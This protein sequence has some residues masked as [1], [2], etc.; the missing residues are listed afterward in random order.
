MVAFEAAGHAPAKLT[1]AQVA[2]KVRPA[3][4]TIR[5]TVFRGGVSEGQGFLFGG[6]GHVLTS[7][8]VLVHATKV[9]VVNAQG[10]TGSVAVVGIDKSLDIAELL[11]SDRETTPLAA[12]GAVPG[13]GTPIVVVGN[14]YSG[15]PYSVLN[16]AV[17]GTG[18][19][20]ALKSGTLGDLVATDVAVQPINSGG[21]LVDSSGRLVGMVVTSDSGR[22]FALPVSRFAA[23]AKSWAR[24]NNI[25]R[26]AP[27]L[28][29]RDARGLVPAGVPLDGF[30]QTRSDAWGA[31]GVH[32]VYVRPPTYEYGGA[33]IDLYV[34]VEVD[35]STA[36]ILFTVSDS[37]SRGFNEVASSSALGDQA[38]FLQRITSSQVTYEVAWRDRN[39]LVYMYL[40]SAIPPAPDVSLQTLIGL[41]SQQ[42]DPIGANLADW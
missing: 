4:V 28:V 20:V 14:I 9:T 19:Q 1:V 10:V 27:P 8:H 36:R 2:A 23:E 29:E 40:G 38:V 7:A 12:A 26:L 16:G 37:K 15:L 34:D 22:A 30:V 31:T 5:T 39:A 25:S 18:G 17:S 32:V 6:G 21:P 41:A 42:E 33:A 3:V 24:E 35:D 13:V 11:T